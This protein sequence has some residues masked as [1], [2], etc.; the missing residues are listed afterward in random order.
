MS[1]M[2]QL[3]DLSG[4]QAVITGGNSGLGAAMAEALG[5]AGASLMLVA[6]RK[7]LL[8]ETAAT[9]RAKGMDVSY[10]EADLTDLDAISGLC[11]DIVNTWGRADILINC[12]GVNTRQ[13]FDEVTPESWNRQMALNLSAP[14]F[15]TQGLAPAMA[16]AGWGRIINMGS[17]QSFRA[18]ANGAHY[19]AAKGGIVQ[20]TRAF[21]QEWSRHGITCNAIAPGFFPTALT[22]P[23]FCN[24][25]IIAKNAASTCIGRNGNIEDIHGIT[26]FLASDASSYITGQTIMLD[27]GLTSR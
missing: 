17:L 4:K 22:A 12:A 9:L 23:M 6:R 24:P 27:G 15:M 5:L 8:E 7:N 3:F 18:F 20:L 13:P 2:Q 26:V 19:G 16:E 1:R 11:S 10:R 25:E 21:A 14:F